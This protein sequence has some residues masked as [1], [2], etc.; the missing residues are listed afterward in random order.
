MTPHASQAKADEYAAALHKA[1]APEFGYIEESWYDPRAECYTKKYP[2]RGCRGGRSASQGNY[3]ALRME[4]PDW[5]RAQH[6]RARAFHHA[7]YECLRVAY[8]A[9]LD[10]A[11]LLTWGRPYS[12]IT[13]YKISGIASDAFPYS[14][15]ERLRSI[16][17]GM[18]DHAA[19]SAAHERVRIVSKS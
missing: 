4:L 12:A 15:K 10:A 16:A 6:E 17:H 13:D 18:T 1:T 14:I 3:R 2:M 5:T 9:L 11:A 8:C 7:Q 19:A